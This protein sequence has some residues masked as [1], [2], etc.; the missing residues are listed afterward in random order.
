MNYQAPRKHTEF[1]LGDTIRP[2][3]LRTACIDAQVV[4]RDWN[5]GIC[6]FGTASN[7][8]VTFKRDDAGVYKCIAVAH[9]SGG[10]I[11][12]MFAY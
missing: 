9:N 5:A 4:R 3:E 1:T 7:E 10:G 12:V 6:T 8:Y 2:D 11:G